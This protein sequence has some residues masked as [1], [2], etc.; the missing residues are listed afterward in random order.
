MEKGSDI[1]R[2]SGFNSK[3]E[4]MFGDKVGLL[5]KKS[6]APSQRSSAGWMPEGTGRLLIGVGRRHSVTMR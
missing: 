2:D 1:F 6:V 3:V 4:H 5:A